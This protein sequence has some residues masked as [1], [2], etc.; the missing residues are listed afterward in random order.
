VGDAATLLVRWLGRVP[1]ADAVELQERLVAER[2]AART[3]D[4]LLLLEHP[5]VI[6]LGRGSDRAHLL[7][8][9]EELRARGIEVH[10]CGRGGDVTYHGPGQLV[11]YPILALRD[12][13]RDAHRYLRDLEEAL[14]RTAADYGVHA[15]RIG[16][17]T[18]IWVGNRKLAAIGVRLSTGWITSHGFALNVGPELDGFSTIVPC[19]IRDRGVTSLTELTGRALRLREVAARVALHLAR[20]FDV[21]PQVSQRPGE[22]LDLDWPTLAARA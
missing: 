7:A 15:E 19:G 4:S 2:R 8:D 1:Y 10:E 3:A 6:T 16:G 14:L 22:R 21:S 12:G 11:G 13:R 17:L 20:V 9:G 18:G 5:P